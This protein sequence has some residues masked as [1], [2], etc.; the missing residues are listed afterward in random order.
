VSIPAPNVKAIRLAKPIPELAP[1]TKAVLPF[2]LKA[3]ES[4]CSLIFSFVFSI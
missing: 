2:K 3:F 1:I 4:G